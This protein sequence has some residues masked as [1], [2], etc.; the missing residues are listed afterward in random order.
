MACNDIQYIPHTL[1]K[2]EIHKTFCAAEASESVVFTACVCFY[3]TVS[4]KE[5]RRAAGDFISQRDG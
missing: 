5:R 1:R 4:V 2:V 3:F